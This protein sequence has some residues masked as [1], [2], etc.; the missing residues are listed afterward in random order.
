M[1]VSMF[2]TAPRI[3][4]A[5]WRISMDLVERLAALFLSW[6]WWILRG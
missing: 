6:S 4:R 2:V 3:T 5:Y 1:N